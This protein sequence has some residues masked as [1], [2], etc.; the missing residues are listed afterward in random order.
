MAKYFGTDGIR[1]KAGESLTPEF[2]LKAGYAIAKAL[3][4]IARLAGSRGRLGQKSLFPLSNQKRNFAGK[5]I[6][7]AP[8]PAVVI[9]QDTRLS[10]PM[11]AGALKSGIL[12]TGTSVIDLG[13][14]PTPALALAV[15][16]IE[17]IGG[18]MVTA[19]HNP[20][21]DNGIKVFR[22]NGIKA[23]DKLEAQ[24]EQIID[25]HPFTPKGP[26]FGKAVSFDF[27]PLYLR[28]LKKMLRGMD[29]EGTKVALDCAFGATS[30]FAKEVFSAFG[31]KP[32]S[33]ND[34]YDGWCVNVN[35]GSTNTQP[36]RDFMRRKRI[37]LG[38][39]FDGDGDRAISVDGKFKEVDGDKILA[40]LT[41]KHKPYLKSGKVVFTEM[42][43]L[44]VEWY[45]KK[46]GIKCY[47]TGVGDYQVLMEMLKR[48][49]L[50]G[51][52]QSGHIILWDKHCTG[53]GILV[54]LFLALTLVK[55]SLSL[56]QMAEEIPTFAQ[57]LRSIPVRDRLSW[58]KNR[59]F[60]ARLDEL[61]RGFEPEVRFYI[62]PSGTE[63]CVRV[64]TESKVHA[65]AETANSQVCELFNSLG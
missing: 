46:H 50:I 58:M 25:E 6:A 21:E 19:S 4:S 32:F 23:G 36:L 39:A 18:V 54:S 49:A 52:E 26:Y 61:K 17:S 5:P 2:A 53:D 48:R 13:I 59:E 40:I 10:S 65:L 30:I 31:F 45:L 34:V 3:G 35:C 14:V 11:L 12:A 24:I 47:R 28:H 64:L 43:N 15:N 41:L 27:F 42:T 60:L 1:G 38:F 37:S 7:L 16:Y 8:F 44:G 33:I 51:G 63:N 20:I 29:G 57:V 9:A 62:R 55:K 22:S 56:S